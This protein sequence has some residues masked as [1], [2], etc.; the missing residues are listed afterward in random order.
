MSGQVRWFMP[1]I[2]L[3][4]TMVGCSN[5]EQSQGTEPL[6]MIKVQLMVP[7]EVSIKEDVALQMK[8]TQGDRPVYDA[9]HVQFQV[10]NEENEPAVPAADKGMMNPEDLEAQ[11]AITAASAGDGIYEANYTFEEAG[12]Y[13]VQVHVTAGSMHAM[14][15]TKV[16][17]VSGEA[18]AQ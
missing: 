3:L 13:V 18:A 4:L 17:V 1:V 9:D 5:E 11:G 6:E 16:T 2:I 14:P 8:L 10:W 7:D 12:V 15:R